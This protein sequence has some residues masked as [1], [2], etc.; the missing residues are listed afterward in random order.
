M[1]RT[2][3]DYNPYLIETKIKFNGNQPR[4]NSLVE[5]YEKSK[6]QTWIKDVPKIFHDEMNGYDFEFLFSGTELEFEDLKKSF[7]NANV[8]S[9]DVKLIHANKLEAREK[10]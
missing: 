1:I 6:L 5:K 9:E 3:L 7:A 8:S 10:S 2:E 4:I